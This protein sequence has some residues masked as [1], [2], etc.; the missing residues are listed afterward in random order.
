M[1]IT[2]NGNALVLTSETKMEDIELLKKVN[3]DALKLKDKDGNEIFAIGAGTNGGIS[4]NGV[5]F[6]GATRDD[7]AFATVT[8]TVPANV[9]NVADW[10]AEK[11]MP[12]WASLEKVAEQVK[13]A[14][15]TYAADKAALLGAT[16]I[17]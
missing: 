1:K 8:V 3:P 11:V 16:T 13:A 10:V 7:D 6:D 12:V 17:A 9:G 5:V 2:V 15:E 4:K 14:T